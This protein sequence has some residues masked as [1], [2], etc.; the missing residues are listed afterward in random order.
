MTY[1]GFQPIH[2]TICHM[3]MKIPQATSLG[4]TAGQILARLGFD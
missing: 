1:S 2:T 3:P 4:Q